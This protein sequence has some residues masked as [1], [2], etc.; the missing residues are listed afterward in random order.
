MC[1]RLL[2]AVPLSALFAGLLFAAGETPPTAAKMP[3]ETTLHGDKRVDDYH[4]LR[5][6]T[7][8]EVLKYLEA[9]N[10]YAQAMMKST[11]E[12]RDKLFQEIVGHIQE[13][14]L[15]VPYRR[16]DY[17][18]YSRT[19]QG[20][21]YPTLCRKKGSLEGDE[22][23]MLDL[24]E[25]AKGHKF[26]GLGGQ[27]VSD[28]G[29]LLAYAIDTTGF[30]EY[31][32]YVKD[33]RSGKTLLDRLE[34]VHSP[35]WSA[36]GNFLFYVAEDAAKRPCKLFRHR[37]GGAQEKD[38]LLLEEKDELY[39][40][41]ISRTLD[42]KYLLVTTNSSEASEVR[43]APSDQPMA[44]PKLL[45]P[46]EGKHRYAVVGHRD[47]FFY[48]RTNRDA[49]NFKLV[50]TPVKDL[51]AW[52]EVIPHRDDVLLEGVTVFA[53]HLVA[54]QRS[55][56]LQRLLVLDLKNG[57]Q[58]EVGMDEP[59]YA[60]FGDTNAEFDARTYRFGYQSFVTPPSVYDYDLETRQRR[61]LKQTKVPNYN[62]A[63]YH[64]ERVWVTAR[65][66]VKVPLS[67]VYKKG[68][69]KDGNAPCLL[70]A[71]GSYGSSSSATFSP[72]RLALLDRGFVFA[73]A[74]IRGGSEM[75]ERWHEDGKMLKKKNTFFDFIDCGNWLCEQR[76]TS[77]HRLAIQGGSAGGLLIGATVNLAPPD[78]CKVAVLEVPFVDVVN[79]M[80]DESLPLTVGE[81]LEWGNPKKKDEYD[82]IKSY[83]PY[84]NLT[85][86]AYPAMLVRTSFH[87]SQVMYW[88][89]AK[90][91][92]KLRT[93]KDDRTPLLFTCNMAGGH[94]GSSG[95]YDHL[96]E[97]AFIYTFVMQQLGVIER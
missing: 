15:T 16:G 26:L 68:L 3:K 69:K 50:R 67:L 46:R 7:N 11:A 35:Q 73:L 86:R 18:Y 24:N 39:R 91:T 87:D 60:L 17:W 57:G 14:D 82:Y 71:Y 92:A 63:D 54:G 40:V 22:E 51:K 2:A 48:L 1:T 88:E 8:P 13:T 19:E 32:L 25:L 9:E 76:Y 95:R 42:R 34:R 27:A 75:G 64:S 23:V 52:E 84:T 44:E 89:P 56:G 78:F 12:F 81:F 66:G 97:T 36:D 83:C 6:K 10:A 29:N 74:H 93:L 80:L 65:D 37:L 5:E 21:Q 45:L 61:L 38:Q 33:L 53:N 59:T 49:K 85:R 43:F 41:F 58:H 28:D 79:T 31:T 55:G 90:Y 96:K 72:A 20:K 62:A 30:R 77:H 47:G 70:H 94:G 4:W